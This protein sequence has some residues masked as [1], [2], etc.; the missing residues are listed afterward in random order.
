MNLISR[1]P[2]VVAE[3]TGTGALVLAQELGTEIAVQPHALAPDVHQQQLCR[4][5]G[6]VAA[7]GLDGVDVY[8]ARP[9]RSGTNCAGAATVS[10][11]CLAA[12]DIGLVPVLPVVSI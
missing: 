12:L 8:H 4:V 3:C 9:L 10:A 6:V 11:L 2:T 5:L 1:G 7:F